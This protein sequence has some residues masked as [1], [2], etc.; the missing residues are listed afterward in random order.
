MENSKV[1]A[2]RTKKS[3][4]H[5]GFAA[6]AL[7]L[8]PAVLLGGAT[9]HANPP[10]ECNPANNT[11]GCHVGGDSGADN[12]CIKAWLGL[13]VTTPWTGAL[14]CSLKVFADGDSPNVFSQDSLYAVL[15]G[16]TFKRLG[17]RTMPDGATPAEVVFSHPNGEPV[18][19]VFANGESLGRPDPGVH[20]K[21][22]ER[23]QMVD[24]EGWATTSG[25]VYYDLYV[26][27]GT[28]RR[29]LATNAT[30]ALGALVSVTDARGVTVTPADMG[31]EIVYDSNGVRQFLTPSRLADVTPAAGFSGYDVAVYALQEPPAKDAAT[32]LY[33]L[34]QSSPVRRL[35][36]RSGNGGKRAVVTI[37]SGGGEPETYQFD[38]ALGEWSLTRPSGVRVEKGRYTQDERAAQ[39]VS[40]TRSPGGA[41][42]ARRESNYKWESWGFAMTNRVEGFGGVTD[43]TT[44]TYY[45]SGNGK[46]QVKTEKRQ[47]GLLIQYAYDNLDRVTSETRSG[48]DMMTETTTYDYTPVDP[49]DP[50]LPVDTRPRTVVKKLDGIECER[51][52]YAYLPFTNIVERVG[53]QGAAYGGTNVLRTVTAFYPVV[54]NDARSGFVASI[55]HEDGK[56]DL[57]DYELSSNIWVRTVTHLH[58]QSPAP[59]SGKTTRDITITNARGE[60]IET[61]TEAYIDGIWYTI[62][63]NRMTYNFEGKRISSENLAGQVTTTAWDCCHKVSEIQPDGSTTTWDYDIEGRM[64]AS[65]RLIPLDMTNVTWLTTCFRYDDLGR[66]VATWQTN[67]AAQVGLPATRTHYDALGRVVARVD[68][69]GNTTTTSYSNNGQVQSVANPNTSTVV[70]ERNADGDTLSITGTAVTPE[71]HTYGTLPDG[72]RWSKTVQG[73]TASS[74]RFTKRYENL[75]G[76]TIREERSGFRGAVLATAHVYDTLG[77]L[78]STVADYEP[79]TEYTYDLLGN[80]IAT[81]RLVGA[82]LRGARDVEETEWRKTETFSSFASFDDNIWFT[83][84]NILSCSDAAIAPLAS[85]SARQL[86][87]LTPALP[88]RIHTTDFRGNLTENELHV[89]V[90]VVMSSQIVPYTTNKPWKILHYGVELQTVSVSA[91]TNTVAYDFLGRQ[92]ANTDGR[93]N[94]THAEYNAVGQRSASIDALGN[95]TIFSH[96]QFGNLASVVNPLGH[97]IVYEHDLR[98]RKTYEGGATYPVRFTY[99]IFGNK[100]TMMTYRNAS[101][102]PESGDVTTWLYDEASNCMTNKVYSDGKGPTYSYTP[103]GKFSQRTWTRGIVTDYA[104]DAWGNLTNTVYSDDTP[105]ISLAYDAFGRQVE[106]HDAAGA[107]TFFYDSYGSLTNEAIVSVAGTNVIERYWDEFG[108]TTGY[109]LNGV[110]QSTLAYDPA[111]G[112]LAT[113]LACGS[114]TPFT[115]NYFD[116]SDL[117]SSLSYPN[118]IMASWA[119][120]ANNQMLQVCNTSATNVISR[121]DYIYDAGGQRVNVSKSGTAFNQD[122]SIA[123]GYNEKCE[124]TNAVAAADSNYRYA[125]KFDDIGNRESAT[126]RGTNNVYSS[127]NLNQ[128][129][130]VDNFVPQFDDDGNQTLVKTATGVWQVQYNG[131]NRPILWSNGD[132]VITMSYDRM[133]RRV[134]KNKQHF[135]YDGFLQIANFEVDASD[136]HNAEC[137]IQFFVWDPTEKVL[138]RP[139]VWNRVSSPAYYAHSGN[140]NVSDVIAANGNVE[141]HYEY[142]PFGA[143]T[144]QRGHY[145]IANPWR[146][147]CEYSDDDTATVYYNFRY[148]EQ[149]HARWMSRDLSE[150][151]CSANLFAA[152]RNNPISRADFVGLKDGM[153][154]RGGKYSCSRTSLQSASAH[155]KFSLIGAKLHFDMDLTIEGKTCKKCCQR[156]TARAG[157]IVDDD[158]ASIILTGKI[159]GGG[160]TFSQEFDSS[161]FGGWWAAPN[162]SGEVYY[163]IKFE[164]FGSLSVSANLGSDRCD[165]HELSGSVCLQGQVGFSVAG[166]AVLDVYWNDAHFKAGGEITGMVTVSLS[167]CYTCNA[168]G[169]ELGVT[170]LCVEGDVTAHIYLM[171]WHINH[172]LWNRGK[173]FEF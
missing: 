26:G 124:L 56:F 99:D 119:Y 112:R 130:A 67:F 138:S 5:V 40:T 125:Y 22:D 154:T 111:T 88:A 151:F 90:P 9:T 46:G 147:S 76:Q 95:R 57:Y 18:H 20:V 82:S 59:V 6:L 105:I 74:P 45:T 14:E 118:G 44:W 23:L 11:C 169:C 27:D 165:N 41:V 150:D 110:R 42:L 108:R 117:K 86:T 1:A 135:T 171:Y 64:I 10:S 113:M 156:G 52:Y 160:G 153:S 7:A 72:T 161:Y 78:V 116:G 122:G 81:T 145:A 77:R 85:S 32:G 131:E 13:G 136:S 139:L 120:D 129:M 25:P 173:C 170:Q 157:E 166:G 49:S 115:W 2:E 121:Y 91:V 60:E 155:K 75:L 142:A 148:Y 127:N 37:Q 73:E 106:V 146:F 65:S 15:G 3:W 107:T 79:S 34:P 126:E 98:G 92:I 96:D 83:Q 36:L 68:Q 137:G 33:A 158:E 162:V 17:Q 89:S 109:A 12:G 144:V 168:K 140:K 16:Y 28:R 123:Y 143:I 62:A 132:T 164:G 58:E 47:S 51:T 50:A 48:P 104:Y 87:G 93:G 97:A 4:V 61:R 172:T 43:T 94:T 38:Y 30:G 101:F 167:R 114:D 24:A 133:G 54:A 63:R 103:D 152:M 29:F 141:A 149:K 53:E 84:T 134:T 100:T 66:Q 80:R 128:Y 31:V 102:G 163:G 19:F 21:M 55:R 71:F 70:Y 8:L 39:I 159:S 35:S 69:L